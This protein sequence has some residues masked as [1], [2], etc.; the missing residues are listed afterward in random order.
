LEGQQRLVG[1]PANGD[2]GARAS[3]KPNEQEQGQD[4]AHADGDPLQKIPEQLTQAHCSI[5]EVSAS[6]SE[7]TKDTSL[8]V[9]RV[10]TESPR[11]GEAIGL[12]EAK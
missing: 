9:T 11:H 1:G 10:T 8:R 3:A 4:R 2:C 6:A 7:I 5:M 12:L